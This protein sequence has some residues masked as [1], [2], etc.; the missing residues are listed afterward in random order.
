MSNSSM[1]SYTNLSPN[2]SGTRT[3]SIDRLTLH[4]VVG[5][6]SVE[7]LG[8]LFADPARQAS[9]NYGIGADGRIGLFVPEDK[10]S[11]CSSSEANDQRAIT[12]E[13]ASDTKSPYAMTDRVYAAII[14]LC[15][16][17][18][19]RNGKTVLTYIPDKAK[20]LAYVPKSNEMLITLH[21]WFA[22]T[23]CPGQWLIQQL[24]VI[25]Q[26][27]TSALSPKTVYR[28]QVGAFTNKAY[29]DAYLDK[30]KKAG[31]PDAYITTK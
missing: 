3:R 30:I 17:I 5:Q 25:A 10:R 27:V 31:F 21:K 6:C 1:I 7:S 2:N 19:K 4:C 11:W 16:D 24:P 22:A 14:A 28:V 20:A 13:C 23:E 12:I 26:T 18:C 15:T 29:A 8:A 9:S